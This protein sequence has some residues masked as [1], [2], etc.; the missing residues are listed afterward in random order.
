MK[1]IFLLL[2]CF[3]LIFSCTLVGC[4]KSGDNGEPSDIPGQT[5]D[6]AT[7]K[8]E[9]DST[10]KKPSGSTSKPKESPAFR[11]KRMTIDGVG[12]RDLK[13][14]ADT[15]DAC[16]GYA[17]GE[18]QK[19]MELMG[20]F[21]KDEGLTVNIVYDE[22]LDEESYRIDIAADSI[23]ISG[24]DGRGVIYGAYGF[25]NRY[26]GVRFLT[27]TVEYCT[28][29]HIVL[30]SGTS[31]TYTPVFDLRQI[32]WHS[33]QDSHV[34]MVKN[35][36]NYGNWTG[37]FAANMGGSESYGG[38]FVH[39]IGRLTGTTDDSQPCLS[40]PEN[41]A[42][43][44]AYIRDV[45][46]KNPETTMV[47]VSQNDNGS[48]CK[49]EKCAAT[50][51]EEG[52]PSGT[53]L[54]FVNAVAADLAE[55]YPNLTID[56]LAYTYTQKAPAVTKPLP[57][58]C[59]RL[60]PINCHFTRTLDDPTCDVNVT[61]CKDLLEWSEIC[62]NIYI[63]DYT[64]NYRYSI[65]TFPNFGILR[66]NMA[67]FADHNVKGM[68]PQGNYYSPSGEFGELR[69]YL[70]AKLMVDPYM[71]AKEYDQH[72]NDFLKGYYGEGWLNIRLYI[73][74]VTAASA[75]SCQDIYDDPFVGVS[76]E[77]YERMEEIFELCWSNAE[78]L[79]GSK[80]ANVKRSRL[81]WRYIRLCLHPDETEARAFV[82]DVQKYGIYWREGS[83]GGAIQKGADLSK[84]PLTWR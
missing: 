47:S 48:Y 56:T 18:F 15:D 43:T 45:M 57:N 26:T 37:A 16:I 79:A 74:T 21:I 40:D 23:T 66:E 54:R 27:P 13:I 71:S 9:P 1:R 78:E 11:T 4:G 73:D 14:V 8:E 60:C 53:L 49:C 35:G 55:D 44:I 51:A 24:G 61:F 20:F 84:S 12:F 25:L 67:F 70:L 10:D 28:D 42:K 75:E 39:T 83:G 29:D 22:A 32:D 34:W 58:V 65:P 6:G 38:L 7:E 62:E 36:I 17:V 77:T 52:S 33:G 69:V 82:K 19:Y 68:F 76:R 81:Q 41:L 80:V 59:I 63:W 30:E 2:L 50:D 64:N 5:D 72:M 46:E 3:S 31:Y